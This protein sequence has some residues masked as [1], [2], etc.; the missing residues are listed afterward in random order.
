MSNVAQFP[1]R[2]HSLHMDEVADK[3]RELTQHNGELTYAESIAILEMIKLDIMRD[4]RERAGFV[5]EE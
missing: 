5:D 2:R 3:I 1:D 4:I